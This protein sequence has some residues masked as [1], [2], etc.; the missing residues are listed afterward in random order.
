MK[1]NLISISTLFL[2]NAVIAFGQTP[3]HHNHQHDENGVCLTDEFEAILS[4]EDPDY[5]KQRQKVEAYIADY[6][7]NHEAQIRKNADG[8]ESTIHRI[9]VVFHIFHAE[10]RDNIS[11]YQVMDAIRVLNEDFRRTN[12]D[13]VNTR[14]IFQSRAADMEVEFHLARVDPN[15]NC[16]DGIVRIET[17]A[18][19]SAQNSIKGLS[20]WDNKRYLNIHVVRTINSNNPLGTVLGYAFF[21]QF[22]QGCINDGI[23]IRHDRV[24]TINTSGSAGRTLTHEA[25]HYFSLHHPFNNGCNGGDFVNDTPP[26]DNPNFGCN[27]NTNS[28]PQNPEPDMIENY[29]DYADD[30]C[31]NIFTVGQR[32]RAK[33]V[34]N[35]ANLRGDVSNPNNLKQVGVVG[36]D[37]CAPVSDFFLRN[38]IICSGESVRFIDASVGT[39]P[40]GYEWSFPGGTPATSTERYPEVTYAEE[41]VYPVTLKVTNNAGSDTKVMWRAVWVKYDDPSPF[42]SWLIEDFELIDVPN[43]NWT[44]QNLGSP[45]VEISVT[46]D[47]AFSGNKSVKFGFNA[48]KEH[49]IYRL[50]TPNIDLTRATSAQL[51]FAYAFA[52]NSAS[53]AD[54]MQLRVSTDCGKT[55]VTRRNYGGMTLQTGP[56][57][58]N[59]EF[60]PA[61]PSEWRQ[62]TFDLGIYTAGNNTIMLMWEFETRG[63]N[64]FY[65]DDINMSVVLGTDRFGS[66][67]LFEVYP[68][69]TH[70][71]L[72]IEFQTLQASTF[73]LTSATGQVLWSKEVP[74]AQSISRMR[75]ELFDQLPAGIYF[76]Q[77]KNGDHTSVKKVVKQ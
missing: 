44:V 2:L 9:P 38:N 32:T 23:V 35:N 73:V 11:R 12:E 15:G 33:G 59:T 40:D 28:C 74:A 65:L 55:W 26:A 4:A 1:L 48:V 58:N 37:V 25:G 64:N 34:L 42:Q 70:G 41:G 21:P 67:A 72:E 75:L 50:V 77:H 31:T 76:L 52:P 49:G 62:E 47:A 51:N 6:I 3:H 69:P 5:V 27:L 24:G 63:G 30:V 39:N 7:A 56:V 19:A 61:N 16:T 66:N 45:E 36:G 13:R 43:G 68:N 17:P 14:A 53:F 57:Q 10:T 71:E 60:V 18:A 22:N 46:S 20:C 8:T 54:R 29:M